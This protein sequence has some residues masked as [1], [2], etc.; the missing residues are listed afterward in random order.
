MI[1]DTTSDFRTDTP[2]GRGPD[3]H[4]PTLRRYHQLLWS[5]PLP[6]GVLF[7]L[8]ATVPGYYLLHRPGRTDTRRTRR[9]SSA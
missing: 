7:E 9:S 2:S 3:S 6:S 8:D 5:E 4:S 1:I